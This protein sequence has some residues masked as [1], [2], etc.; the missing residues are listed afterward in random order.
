MRHLIQLKDGSVLSW[1]LE[2]DAEPSVLPAFPTDPRKELVV[3]QLLNGSCYAEVVT[4]PEQLKEAC[5]PGLPLG[6]LFFHVN[7]EDLRDVCGTLDVD[8]LGG[9]R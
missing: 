9:G 6:R 4:T 2:R 5:G 7:K 8:T 3:S 1:L